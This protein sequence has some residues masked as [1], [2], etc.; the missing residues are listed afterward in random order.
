MTKNDLLTLLLLWLMTAL[1]CPAQ[2]TGGE[3]GLQCEPGGECMDIVKS[4]EKT[5]T[6]TM[7]VAAGPT[8]I[9][10]TYLSPEKFRGTEVRFISHTLRDYAKRRWSREIVH[11]VL[12]STADTRGDGATLLTAM[13]NLQ[14]G[15][16]YNWNVCAGRVNIRVG[17][18]IDGTIGCMYNTNNGNNPAQARLSL[19]LTPS[20]AVTWNF[21]LWH[22]PWSLR[23]ELD[24]PVAGLTFSPA[25]GQSYYEIFSRGN[26]DHNIVATSPANAP[27]LHQLLSLDFRLRRSTFRIGYLGDIRQHRANSLKYHQYTH[28]IVIG[29]VR[30]FKIFPTRP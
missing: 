13:Y 29:W 22:R 16:H 14:Y 1:P 5:V 6:N 19:E 20:A 8:N 30:T 9:L 3:T 18:L 27:E 10:D 25:Y 26:Y 2:E 17:G 12:A 11:H 4:K 21:H 28:A 15:W 23:Y 24:V 7:M